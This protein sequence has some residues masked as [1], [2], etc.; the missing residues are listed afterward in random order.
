MPGLTR[1]CPSGSDSCSPTF[2]HADARVARALND[3]LRGL[4]PADQENLA[5]LLLEHFGT[6]NNELIPDEDGD[7]SDEEEFQEVEDMDL[8]ED[9]DV[10]CAPL[11]VANPADEMIDFIG[12]EDWSSDINDPEL[13]R[14]ETFSKCTCKSHPDSCMKQFDPTYV[15]RLRAQMVDATLRTE[16]KKM[17]IMGRISATIQCGKQTQCSKRTRQKD[18]TRARVIYMVEGKRICRETFMFLHK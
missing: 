13:N 8:D 11:V 18:R 9:E 2:T 1:S 7:E 4:A 6:S 3:S 16:E 10:E 14:I 5:A 17:F 15:L 12:T